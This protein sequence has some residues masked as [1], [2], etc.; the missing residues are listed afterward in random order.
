MFRKMGAITVG[1]VTMIRALKRNDISQVRPKIKWA[2]TPAPKKVI[3]V[4]RVMSLVMT[5]P[6]LE[7][8]E[9][10]RVSPPSKRI[11]ETAQN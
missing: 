10:F 1:P 5:G 7:T 11:M 2:D 4:P 6:T 3:A 9:I 8:S